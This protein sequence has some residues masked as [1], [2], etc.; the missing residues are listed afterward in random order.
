MD[1]KLNY[2]IEKEYLDNVL[3]YL[4]D[5]LAEYIENRR[6]ISDSIVEYRKKFI[7]E[8]RDDDD[9]I[10]DYFDHENYKNEQIFMVVERK[11]KEI[12]YL[13]KT[14]YFGKIVISE[15]GKEEKF[16]IGSYGFD[17]GLEVPLIIDWRAPIASL[18]YQGKIGSLSYTIPSGEDICVSLNER[19]Q[20]LI[21]DGKIISMF[22]S[23][24]DVKDEFLKEMLSLKSSNKLKTIVQ[25]IQINQDK[26][27]REDRR[28]SIIINGVAGSGKT[29]IALHR[30]AYLLYNF[31]NYFKDRVLILCPNKIFM[32]YI[33]SVLPSLGEYGGVHSYTSE[34][35]IYLSTGG[36]LNFNSYELHMEKI[37]NDKEYLDEFKFKGSSKVKCELDKFILDVEENINL[38][39]DIYF[40]EELII[41]YEEL[42]RLFYKSFKSR[43]I[44]V[45]IDLIRKRI[46]DRINKVRNS[47]VFKIKN[48]YES[49]KVHP[50]M[51][52][53]YDMLMKNEIYDVV[54]ESSDLKSSLHYLKLESSYELYREFYEDYFS[55]DLG[56]L[57]FGDLVL[58]K[59]ID[60]KFYKPKK[61]REYKL[62][63][64]DEGQDF[65]YM[66][67]EV[68]KLCTEASS[69]LVV[70]DLNQSIIKFEENFIYS[71][72]V[73]ENKEDF[74][75][76]DS[77]RSTKNIIDYSLKYIDNDICVNSIRNGEDVLYYECDYD[78]L[79]R[80]LIESINNLRLQDE[81]NIGIIVL[82]QSMIDKVY[83][84]IRSNFYIKV[85][86]NED[87][88]YSDNG[89]FLMTVYLSKGLEFDSV[90]VI[91]SGFEDNILYIMLTR[92]MHKAI[93]IKIKNV[94][95]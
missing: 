26:I 10:I 13:K 94:I 24:I 50:D 3:V 51:E 8:Y 20:F 65:S 78:D 22:D 28:K 12:L 66:F 88:V 83:N 60:I 27:I 93:H 55:K 72:R 53:Y 52:N 41:D 57:D 61:D 42:N 86:N 46:F 37:L 76:L 35:F 63:V 75:I 29:S 85:I 59:Y 92:A 7:E 6:D 39:G 67:Y 9:K 74:T 95:P 81:T 71:T 58:I 90:L 48:K 11:I 2:K 64:I 34:D 31:R 82:N 40:R 84:M 77:Y 70:G 54:R 87:H 15:D 89:I 19:I 38:G 16:Y 45:R 44:S 36:D 73:L 25:T 56:D 30:I 68:I 17:V 1:V 80:L 79:R 14:P 62:V 69:Y 33:S 47:F 23:E 91:D 43:A 32:E 5:K 49:M 18:F 4:N 21:R